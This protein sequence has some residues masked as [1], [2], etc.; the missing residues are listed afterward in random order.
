MSYFIDNFENIKNLE[1]LD[2][3]Y[4][5]IVRIREIIEKTPSKYDTKKYIVRA[6][7]KSLLDKFTKI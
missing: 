1:D 3:S 7:I 6:K 4:D 5:Q 2:L